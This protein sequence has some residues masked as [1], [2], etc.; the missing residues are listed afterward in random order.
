MAKGLLK[1]QEIPVLPFLPIT[2]P[3]HGSLETCHNEGNFSLP[4][5]SHS[6]MGI[7]K[8]PRIVNYWSTNVVLNT[9]FASKLMNT[10]QF[11]QTLSFFHLNDNTCAK[12]TGHF[13]PQKSNRPSFR[14]IP[15]Q[16]RKVKN[17]PKP[18]RRIDHQ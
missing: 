4:C 14:S 7:V 12:G 11:R 15:S 16:E 3:I 18:K 6:H 17:R 5:T 2:G 10:E 8:K 1:M 9:P 13:T